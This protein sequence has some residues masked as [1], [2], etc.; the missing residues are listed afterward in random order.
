MLGSPAGR[1]SAQVTPP[2]RRGAQRAWLLAEF[3]FVW[4]TN[5]P[6]FSFE[7]Q[8]K[9]HLDLLRCHRFVYSSFRTLKE[10]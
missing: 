2:P 6:A 1:R 8:K 10:K 5:L 3:S 9:H 4:S 7:K